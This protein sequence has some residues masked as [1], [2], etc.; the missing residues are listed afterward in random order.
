MINLVS[1]EINGSHGRSSEAESLGSIEYIIN[2]IR[3]VLSVNESIEYSRLLRRSWLSFLL[4][5]QMDSG[6]ETKIIKCIVNR[7]YFVVRI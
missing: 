1:Q 5:Q 4:W 7:Q 2:K 3:P 6:V